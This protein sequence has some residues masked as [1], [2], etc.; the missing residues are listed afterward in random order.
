M[1]RIKRTPAEIEDLLRS[2]E[3]I[4]RATPRPFFATRA[5]ARLQARLDPSPLPWAFR[6]LTLVGVMTL[7]LALNL[8]A[9]A[10]YRQQLTT[11]E[12]AALSEERFA[13][14]WQL[15]DPFTW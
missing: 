7:I 9:L 14:D 12:E 11:A 6:P 15:T 1:K 3:G 13:S 8:S 5:E 2:L 10:L 4:E